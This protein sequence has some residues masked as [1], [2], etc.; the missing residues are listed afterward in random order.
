M[1]FTQYKGGIILK[2]ILFIAGL[3]L[4]LAI[5]PAAAANQADP[6]V[7][8][9]SKW[10]HAHPMATTPGATGELVFKSPRS[11]VFVRQAAAG[12][13]LP[14]HYHSNVD[15]MVYVVE[16]SADLLTNGEWVKLQPGD[17][18]V[19]PR[20]A[21]HALK[22]SQPK[23]VKFISVFTPP[24]PANGDMVLIP[25]GEPLLSPPG[26][27]DANPAAGIVVSLKEWQHAPVG[28]PAQKFGSV[29]M[30][31]NMENDGLKSV[32]IIDT[33]RSV[34]MLREAGYGALHRH[35]QDQAD[36]IVIVVSGSARTVSGNN[37]YTLGKNDLQI[38]PM[39]TDHHMNLMLGENIRFVTVFGL[40]EKQTTSQP[41]NLK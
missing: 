3:L 2:R 41:A 31:D 23:G 22:V 16:G 39:G 15:E 20:G 13:N 7:I 9:L 17:V 26:L 5:V 34:V 33:P 28:Q 32:S 8:N 40:P 24:Q 14:P 36:E 12:T 30:P 38:I 6:V 29:S 10:Y 1:K 21:V 27:L 35:K 4:L 18:H 37:S 11:A 19:N 25:A